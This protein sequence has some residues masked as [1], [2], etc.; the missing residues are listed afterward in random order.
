MSAEPVQPDPS[1][2]DPIGPV[3]EWLMAQALG[4]P[5]LA[6][7]LVGCCTRLAAA[8]VPVVRGY[9]AFRTLHPLYE[10]AALTWHRDAGLHIDRHVHG[11]SA[12][13]GWRRSPLFHLTETGIPCLR[14]RLAGP[15]AQLDFPV[16]EELRDAG[17]TDYLAF[18]VRFDGEERNGVVGSWATDRPS[19]FTDDDLR[20]L[21]RIQ[22]RLAVACKVSIKDQIAR[23]IVNAYLGPRAG[24][25]VLSGSIRRGDGR[26]I[27]AA[28]WYVDL[29]G[30]TELADAMPVDDLLALLN[31][32]FECTAG[33]VLERGGEVLMLI[34]DAVLAMFP[35]AEGGPGEREACAAALAAAADAEARVAAV[36]GERR[37][38][39]LDA[40]AFGIGLHLGSVIYGNIGVPDRLEFTVV[41]PAVNE[42]ARIEEL[43]KSLDR[44]ILASRAFAA[45]LPVAWESLGPRTLRGVAGTHEI[46]APSAHGEAADAA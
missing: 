8:G 22:T 27:R 7:L 14:R 12:N 26:A 46:L 6:D 38:A 25:Q 4:S 40:L 21:R 13:E 32:Y 2:A 17:L 44:P 19:G 24:A 43:T 18:L 37:R 42:V 30:S 5:R 3:A 16:L 31:T 1:A 23:N 41:G 9:V 28:L 35:I 34:G 20:A 11:S 33:A 29:R 45:T 10:S 36:N 39:G 15:D